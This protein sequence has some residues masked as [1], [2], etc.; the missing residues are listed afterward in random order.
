MHACACAC[1]FMHRIIYLHSNTIFDLL[2]G[3]QDCFFDM[4]RYF[5]ECHCRPS[6]DIAGFTVLV[7]I[8]MLAYIA[9]QGST[10]NPLDEGRAEVTQTTDGALCREHRK[11]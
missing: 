6:L 5:C 3:T 4:E 10:K 2:A 11:S 8:A 7:G 1:V 9:L